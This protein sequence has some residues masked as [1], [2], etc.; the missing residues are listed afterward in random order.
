MWLR[1]FLLSLYNVMRS[2][3]GLDAASSQLAPREIPWIIQQIMFCSLNHS[4]LTCIPL[5]FIISVLLFIRNHDLIFKY[6]CICVN[7]IASWGCELS[8]PMLWRRSQH[9]FLSDMTLPLKLFYKPLWGHIRAAL[10]IT[11]GKK[12]LV[13]SNAMISW[14]WNTNSVIMYCFWRATSNDGRTDR[15]H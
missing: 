1:C 6:Q 14:I 5:Q 4:M 9:Y 12:G 11:A 15:Y 7:W 8:F 13:I 10:R 2:T 3:R